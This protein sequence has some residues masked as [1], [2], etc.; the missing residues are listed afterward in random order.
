MMTRRLDRDESAERGLFFLQK[1]EY[2]IDDE[3]IEKASGIAFLVHEDGILI[4]CS[5]VLLHL[6][7]MPGE[8]VTIH[9]AWNET[10]VSIDAMVLDRGWHGPDWESLIDQ[11][12][13]NERDWLRDNQ[14]KPE[15]FKEDCALLK[16][17]PESVRWDFSRGFST[18]R[19][20]ARDAFLGSARTLPLGYPGYRHASGV[21]CTAWNVEYQAMAGKL[22]AH[23]VAFRGQGR[24]WKDNRFD[25]ETIGPGHSGGPIWDEERRLVVGMVRGAGASGDAGS[26]LAVD[27]RWISH[28]TESPIRLDLEAQQLRQLC[29]RI[30]E[31]NASLRYL[32]LLQSAIPK[33]LIPLRSVEIKKEEDALQRTVGAHLGGDA[34]EQVVKSLDASPVVLV[35]GGA[36]S[37][38]STLLHQLATCLLDA[39][40]RPILPVLIS[41][42]AFLAADCDLGKVL[43]GTDESAAGV[44]RCIRDNGLHVVILLDALDEVDSAQRSQ[45]L[46]RIGSPEL[47]TQVVLASRPFED[48]GFARFADAPCYA[49]Q[50]LGEGEVQSLAAQHLPDA[51]AVEQFRRQVAEIAWENAAPVPLQIVM[52]L[53]AYQSDVLNTTRPTDL[54]FE[55]AEHL[56]RSAF[57][58]SGREQ[59]I[60]QS[61]RFLAI[62]RRAAQRFI[63]GADTRAAFVDAVESI[64]DDGNCLPARRW[65]E[66]A[67]NSGLLS[68]QHSGEEAPVV[69]PHRTIAEALAAQSIAEQAATNGAIALQEFS[70]ALR[71]HG[72][73]FA[74]M[75]VAALERSESGR[76]QAQLCMRRYLQNGVSNYKSTITA[77]QILGSGISL[78]EDLRERF[79][80][81]LVVLLLMPPGQR[82]G[83]ISCAEVFSVD[84]LP[85]PVAIARRDHVRPYV[86]AFMNKRL[87]KRIREAGRP[88]LISPREEMLLSRLEMQGQLSVPIQ[89]AVNA[90]VAIPR[91]QARQPARPGPQGLTDES[92]Y[93]ALLL[94]TAIER[95]R[96]DAT[97]FLGGLVQHARGLP[98][99]AAETVVGSYIER[100]LPPSG[101]Q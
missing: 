10:P 63:K 35:V 98:G 24:P 96:S 85:D 87:S 36:G 88:V 57:E 2:P 25:G 31:Q 26:V 74:I 30:A 62:A 38:K 65:V 69:W 21:R 95:L 73:T 84:R 58:Q 68:F 22:A 12:S 16:L 4:T 64:I 33:T 8:V 93:A 75:I 7:K 37:G 14:F 49:L 67:T 11:S 9:H 34:V 43:S 13:R 80:A 83:N 18:L 81:L 5:H 90:S 27:P 40:S 91:V 47:S 29:R 55:L 79:V 15:T 52:A 77:V 59:G 3:L 28:I 72:R 50:P 48:V 46:A 66:I 41:A 39:A 42:R 97:G 17:M 56:V 61:K 6:N 45:V 71:R 78:D 101:L 19:G 20:S 32:S 92:A 51:V 89:T 70:D 99:E 86:L 82:V 53:Y 100:L 94:R 44:H 1:G 60:E 54:T 76:P 23:S